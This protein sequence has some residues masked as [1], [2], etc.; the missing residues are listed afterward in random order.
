MLCGGMMLQAQSHFQFYYQ[1]HGSHLEIIEVDGWAPSSVYTLTFPAWINGKP[2]THIGRDVLIWL[3]PKPSKIIIPEGVTHIGNRAF[4]QIFDPFSV[5]LPSTLQ[6]IGHGAFERSNLTQINLPSGLKTIGHSS[7]ADTPITEI[8]FPNGLESIGAGAFSGT[9]LTQVALPANLEEVGGGAFSFI[10]TLTSA[11]T[12][13]AID[14]LGEG[15]FAFCAELET[16]ILGEGLTSISP[17]MFSMCGNLSSISLPSSLRRIGVRAFDYCLQL[18]T[19]TLPEGLEVIERWAFRYVDI[20]NLTIPSTVTTIGDDAFG[21]HSLQSVHFLGDAPSMRYGAFANLNTF[22]Y[23]SITYPLGAQ[24]FT[25]PEWNGYQTLQVGGI[26]EWMH[27]RG[28]DITTSVLT[29]AAGSGHTLLATYAFGLDSDNASAGLPQMEMTPSTLNLS[30][31]GNTPGVTYAASYSDD[32][33]HWHT[34]LV[35]V[36]APDGEGRVTASVPMGNPAR[37]M[38]VEVALSE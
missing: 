25:M 34:D 24:G 9:R 10:P 32:L 15:I 3:H 30:F 1:D 13:G 35:T 8:N 21:S 7:F 6:H 28:I 19:I 4:F 11:T 2:V 36:S 16:V 29:R 27:N 22:S 26:H 18:Q 12:L 20:S 38:R 37:F 23:V 17:S 14:Q 5:V 31:L 33:I